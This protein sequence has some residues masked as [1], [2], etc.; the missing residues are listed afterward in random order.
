MRRVILILTDGLRPDA[1]TPG[2]MP[3]LHAL[4]S[5]YTSAR[6]ATTVRP[7]RTVAALASLATGV[8]PQTHGLIEPGLGFLRR[9][10][11]V[12][13]LA[14]ELVRHN[15]PTWVVAGELTTMEWSI[16]RVLCTAAGTAGL[17]TSGRRARDVA[18]SAL[19]IAAGVTGVVFVYLNDCDLA[20]HAHGWMSDEYLKAAAELD[21]AVAM[22]APLRHDSLLVVASDHG[23]GGVSS[24]DHHEP[25]ATNDAIPLV[26][27]GPGIARGLRLVDPVSLLD[28]PPTMCRWLGVPTPDGYEGRALEEAF[29][30]AVYAAEA[31][32]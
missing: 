26:L 30:L 9:L 13:P 32:S 2:R 6:R 20:G 16:V 27:A 19:R 29:E 17:A 4:A 25:H 21:R 23:G 22:L 24:N 11:S 8:A 1:I 31:D 14:R 10:S 28:V 18:Q 12:K 15:V 3:S 5:E 7:S